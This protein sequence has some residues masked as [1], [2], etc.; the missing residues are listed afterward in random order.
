MDKVS[1][2]RDQAYTKNETDL[3]QN[4]K[5]PERP[6]LLANLGSGNGKRTSPAWAASFIEQ[7]AHS[8]LSE[9]RQL[10]LRNF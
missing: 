7:H 2:S 1:F 6:T 3:N 5:N 9:K 4:K 8:K 10:I